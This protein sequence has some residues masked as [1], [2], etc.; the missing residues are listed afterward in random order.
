MLGRCLEAP[1]TDA[2][3]LTSAPRTNTVSATG[4]VFACKK[5]ISYLVM[6]AIYAM[7]SEHDLVPLLGACRAHG[8][9]AFKP[10][11]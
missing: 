11:L 9:R 4:A 8:L 7:A 10:Q 1:L 3:N 2:I 6:A 5:H